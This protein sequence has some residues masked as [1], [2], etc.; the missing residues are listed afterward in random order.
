MI[1]RLVLVALVVV[2]TPVQQ[3]VTQP[4]ITIMRVVAQYLQQKVA[5]AVLDI[6]EVGHLA[7]KMVGLVVVEVVVVVLVVLKFKPLSQET[8]ELMDLAMTAAV[9]MDLHLIMVEA[10]AVVPVLKDQMV[11]QPTQ[12]ARVGT[13]HQTLEPL[14]A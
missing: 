6:L 14:M 9:G 3:A 2:V 8:Q 11:I 4:L 5:A 7:A 1:L 13:S 12:V 10:V